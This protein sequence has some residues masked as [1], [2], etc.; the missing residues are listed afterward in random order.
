MTEMDDT[1]VY[2]MC[3]QCAAHVARGAA[4]HHPHAMAAFAF[5]EAAQSLR[6]RAVGQGHTRQVE[7]KSPG[8]TA[9]MVKCGGDH[10]CCAEKERAG[11]A[12]DDEI[13]VMSAVLP[14]GFDGIGLI[15][16]QYLLMSLHGDHARHPMHE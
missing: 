11:N 13:R 16:L 1:T 5:D 6:R 8:P 15:F 9:D 12:I 3:H 4:N 10:A 7:H 2:A 14:V